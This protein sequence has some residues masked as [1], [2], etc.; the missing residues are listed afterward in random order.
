LEARQSTSAPPHGLIDASSAEVIERAT[1]VARQMLGMDMAFVS[2]TR[3]GVQE[4][5]FVAGEYE[6]FQIAPGT[7]AP[8]AGT[9]CEALLDGRIDNIVADAAADP[10][11]SELAATERCGIGSYI[12]VPVLL[13][14]GELYG[15]FCVLSHEPDPELQERDVQFMQVLAH[16][17]A[18]QVRRSEAEAADRRAAIAAGEVSALVAAL[19]ARDGY[20]GEHS[21]AVVALALAV[22]EEMGICAR[23]LI[24][25]ENA[26]RLHDIGKIGISDSVLR[27]PCRLDH[28]EWAEMRRH[29][30]VGQRIIDS[31]P[32]LA[33]LSAV[34]RAEH[35]R[36]D[37]AG[38]PDGLAGEDIPLAAR[39][40]LVCD[41]YHAMTSDRPY[42]R[43][44]SHEVAL[45]EL[46]EHAGTQFCPR[47]VAAALRVISGDHG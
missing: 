45:R 11:V 2:D 1:E 23:E 10:V 25:V 29:P 18:D 9:Y 40:V 46:S 19:E 27:K 20:T 30:E 28:D 33:H 41:A 44:L 4:Y 39:I 31:M 26:A 14:T 35:E 5:S 16:L 36:W 8:L 6:S 42:R 21:E 22:A 32:G 15:T 13:D 7:S 43:A 17:I 47:T 37:G 12:G 34:I 38:Y 24:D 3:S